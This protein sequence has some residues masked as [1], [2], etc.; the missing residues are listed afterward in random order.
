MLSATTAF[1]QNDVDWL[2]GKWTRTNSKPG[3]SGVEIWTK[4]GAN[5]LIGR[6][7]SLKGTDTSFVEK[8]KIV[9]KDGKLFY[10]ADV[11]DNHGETWFEFTTITVKSFVCENP[12]HDFPK[13][14]SYE[15]NGRELKA[16]IS[17]D[18]KSVD[19]LF[20]RQD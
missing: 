20:T 10:V 6:G 9:R 16:R 18:G 5:E 17:G 19:Y 13:N 12:K 2:V 14:I 8:L 7:I 4:N 15:L 1:A 3:R 11:P